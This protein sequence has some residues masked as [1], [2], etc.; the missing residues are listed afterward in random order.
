MKQMRLIEVVR[1]LSENG[2]VMLRSNG[3]MVYGNGT[4]RVALAH[5]RN[6]APGVVRQVF[7]AIEQSKNAQPIV[8][9]L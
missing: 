6:V 5:D 7:K 1:L 3:H 9:S 4:V 2:F 8:K